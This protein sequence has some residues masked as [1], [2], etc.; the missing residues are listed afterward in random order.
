MS[1]LA[2]EVALIDPGAAQDL[3]VDFSGI[4]RS[5][6]LN[7]EDKMNIYTLSLLVLAYSAAANT[8]MIA[9]FSGDGGDT[10]SDDMLVDIMATSGSRINTVTLSPVITGDDLRFEIE[11]D[12]PEAILILKYRPMLIKRGPVRYG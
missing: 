10:W 9:R 7:R 11:M 6:S 3:G 8:T 2:N 4:W 12:Q 1:T 5:H